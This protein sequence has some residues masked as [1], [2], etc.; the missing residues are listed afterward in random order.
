MSRWTC[1]IV[2][3]AV[4]V[5]C[6]SGPGA[7]DHTTG[8]TRYSGGDGTT[9][10]RAVIVP[11]ASEQTSIDAEYAW[12]HQHVPG[13]KVTRQELIT[14]GGRAYDKLDVTLPEG[15]GKSFYFDISGGY[16]KLF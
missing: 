4:L 14:Q 12:L 11:G 8:G 9:L 6:R 10:E 13:G 16:G 15:N 5:A 2:L 3:A 7:P 1:I